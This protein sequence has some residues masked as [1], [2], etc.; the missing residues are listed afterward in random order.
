MHITGYRPG[1]G[2]YIILEDSEGYKIKIIEVKPHK[3]LSLQ[4]HKHRNEHWVI[5]S[6][7]AIVT[8]NDKTFTL[9]QNESTYIKAGDKHRLLNDTDKTLMIIEAQVRSYTGEDDIERY[10]DDFSRS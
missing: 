9:Y 2:I 5:V 4:S 1:G 8:I 6:G 10:D 3:R 7:T